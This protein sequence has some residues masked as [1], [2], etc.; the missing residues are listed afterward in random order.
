MLMQN[1]PRNFWLKRDKAHPELI[2][3][4]LRQLDQALVTADPVTVLSLR[5]RLV[6][7][8]P[9]LLGQCKAGPLLHQADQVLDGSRSESASLSPPTQLPADWLADAQRL[10]GSYDELLPATTRASWA[11]RL[12]TALD[13]AQLVAAQ[14]GQ[15]SDHNR[16]YLDW[17]GEHPGIFLAAGS[18][19]RS[20]IALFRSDLEQAFP[21]L[22]RTVD[23][24]V[25]LW[26]ALVEMEDELAFTHQPTFPAHAVGRLWDLVPAG[27]L[28]VGIAHAYPRS[29][30]PPAVSGIAAAA[31]TPLPRLLSWYSPDGRFVARS[32]LSTTPG[33]EDTTVVR[34]Y[35]V[36][37]G[38]P[39]CQLARETIRLASVASVCDEEGRALFSLADLRAAG[40]DLL[41]QVGSARVQWLSHAEK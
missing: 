27:D 28:P 6:R 10:E 14:V 32:V 22:A 29:L 20:M 31:E 4:W 21:T 24:F 5:G 30:L 1:H 40:Q 2:A 38:Q 37:D 9:E 16:R 39:A 15:A 17:V 25:P 23:L 7:V 34:L 12:L 41:L 36:E 35:Q 33:T 13:D 11:E 18:W 3:T 19:I 26:E 8:D